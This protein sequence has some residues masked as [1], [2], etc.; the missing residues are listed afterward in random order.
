MYDLRYMTPARKYFKKLKD[1]GLISAYTDALRG[2]AADPYS[3]EAK[4]G[5]LTG[6]YCKDVYHAKINYE[7]AYRIIE[8]SDQAVIVILA[9]TRE[10]F[11]DEL[12]RYMSV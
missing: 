5:D 6:I 8:G 10:N 2:I 3:G 7:I 11:Y 12:K 1:K 9:G 4:I